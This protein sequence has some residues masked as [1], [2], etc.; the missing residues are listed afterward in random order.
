[1]N[2]REILFENVKKT[3]LGEEFFGGL[4]EYSVEPP[5]PLNANY[6]LTT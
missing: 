4:C 5:G 1:M 2:L 6:F 3:L